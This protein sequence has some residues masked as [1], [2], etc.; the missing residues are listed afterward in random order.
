MTSR[1]EDSAELRERLWRTLVATSDLHIWLIRAL[2]GMDVFEASPTPKK[3]T[4]LLGLMDRHDVECTELLKCNAWH[5][6][7][8]VSADAE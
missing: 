8:E 4:A 5:D 3:K 6:D 7:E 1:D 2:D